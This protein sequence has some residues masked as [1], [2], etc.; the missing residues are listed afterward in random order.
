MDFLNQLDIDNKDDN[1]IFTFNDKNENNK[2][3]SLPFAF[4]SQI[5]ANDNTAG[6]I[7]F[8]N[9]IKSQGGESFT[10]GQIENENPNGNNN[11][12][13]FD[14]L[15]TICEVPES[16]NNIFNSQSENGFLSVNIGQNQ[17]GLDFIN[18]DNEKEENNFDISQ[19]QKNNNNEEF[20][21]VDIN[22]LFKSSK[23]KKNENFDKSSKSIKNQNYQNINDILSIGNN[24]KASNQNDNSDNKKNPTKN[25]I[26]ININKKPNNISISNVRNN[27]N[28]VKEQITNT[29]NTEMEKEKASI[30]KKNNNTISPIPNTNINNINKQLQNQLNNPNSTSNS[31]SIK[32]NPS[33]L[34]GSSSNKNINYNIKEN[35][36][37]K[38]NIPSAANIVIKP[39]I[40][41]PQQSNNLDDIDTII[42]LNEN[43]KSNNIPLSNISNNLLSINQNFLKQDNKLDIIGKDNLNY[44]SNEI[45]NI[46]NSSLNNG[47]RSEIEPKDKDLQNID[48]LLSFTKENITSKAKIKPS[49]SISKDK[50]NK[51]MYKNIANQSQYLAN[52]TQ[53]ANHSLIKPLPSD[54]FDKK[55][56][57]IKISR[58]EAMP[59]SQ[60]ETTSKMMPRAETRPPMI[61]KIEIVQKY[62]DLAYRL[63]KIREKAKE[64]RN[65][66]SYFTQLIIANEN[67][68]IVYPNV[69]RQ[70]LDDYNKQINK[71]LSLMKI[72]NNKMNE[73]NNEF[74]EE[75]K[76]YSLAFQEQ[77]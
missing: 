51:S 55:S 67:Y 30:N 10:L 53:K 27:N 68:N 42:S 28:E 11:F 14:F 2:T 3:A 16:S 24:D 59:P 46:F 22:N 40:S 23:T 58:N 13:G 35:K 7:N 1:S 32:V 47:K 73:M 9:D 25:T 62:N 19:F 8:L 50:N 61:S 41:K 34:P 12:G 66:G 33:I 39:T 64:Y 63:N 69:L 75:V 18:E 15:N 56:N 43:I 57:L 5:S 77:K 36:E 29:I 54:S 26:Q 6:D 20:I 31:N 37:N 48:N 71:L 72:K 45:S 76:K 21:N 44:I 70:L 38:E 60:M 17:G 4:S 65:L 49:N 74:H 52:N